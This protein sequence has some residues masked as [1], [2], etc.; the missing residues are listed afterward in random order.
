MT[1]YGPRVN[2]LR[3]AV[4]FAWLAVAA[5]GGE[6]ARVSTEPVIVDTAGAEARIRANQQG[7]PRSPELVA[8]G[9]GPSRTSETGDTFSGGIIGGLGA[10]AGAQCQQVQACCGEYEQAMA[11]LS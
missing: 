4:G 7:T 10:G 6:P 5:C 2:G 3:M 8:S 9:T 1:S 11:E